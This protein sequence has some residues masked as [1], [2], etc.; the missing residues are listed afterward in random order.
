[1]PSHLQEFALHEIKRT[2]STTAGAICSHFVD[3]LGNVVPGDD[4]QKQIAFIEAE[5]KKDDR[6]ACKDQEGERTG[7][8]FVIA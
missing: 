5:L 4:R 6:L 3:R 8:V 2:G 7:A 1:M